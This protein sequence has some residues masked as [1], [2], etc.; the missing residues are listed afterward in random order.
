M[1]DTQATEPASPNTATP[2]HQRKTKPAAPER[3]LSKK[4]RLI[5]LLGSRNGARTPT[6]CKSLGWQ[7]HTVRAA[8]SGLRK[9]GYGITTSR[10]ARDGVAVYKITSTPEVSA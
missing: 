9:E 8:L 4:S 3:P 7:R 6:L 10:S 2:K 5:G 1:P